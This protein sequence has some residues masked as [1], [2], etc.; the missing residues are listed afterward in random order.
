[1]PY[2][3]LQEAY[4]LYG[5]DYV[6]TSVMR[7][8]GV[9]DTDSF[10]VALAVASN[11]IDS[12]LGTLY[13]LP[14]SPTPEIVKQFNV[15]IAIYR[16]S[17]DAGTGTDEKRDRYKDAVAWL[18]DISTGKASLG[19]IDENKPEVEIATLEMSPNNPPRLFTR[20]SLKRLL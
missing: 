4:D 20:E 6:Q 12:Y 16:C 7:P 1:M 17:A 18:K 3:T 8:S 2:A 15:D 5:E 13:S 9:P 10:T 11:H 14:V 19:A